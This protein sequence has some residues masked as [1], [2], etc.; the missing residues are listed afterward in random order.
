MLLVDMA[1]ADVASGMGVNVCHDLK[2]PGPTVVPQAGVA[3]R[4]EGD[5]T[6]LTSLRIEVV[7]AEKGSDVSLR[8]SRRPKRKA[9]VSRQPSPRR[10]N[11]RRSRIQR[12]IGRVRDRVGMSDTKVVSRMEQGRELPQ[13]VD[14]RVI[15][16]PN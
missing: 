9:P 15:R 6:G 3:R 11:C 16:R 7:V 2:A 14:D 13:I 8:G 1:L 12:Q 4:V 5:R 10:R